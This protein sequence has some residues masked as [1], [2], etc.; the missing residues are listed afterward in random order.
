MI[1][2]LELYPKKKFKLDHSQE[3]FA[4]FVYTESF[5]PEERRPFELLRQIAEEKPF[6]FYIIQNENNSVGIMSFWNFDKFVYAE[7]FA[8]SPSTRGNGIG[9]KVLNK[10]HSDIIKPI[11]LEVE[12]PTNTIAQRRIKLYERNGFAL[13]P[14]HYIQPPYSDNMPCVEMKLMTTR[15]FGNSKEEFKIIKEIIHREVYQYI[16]P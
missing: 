7:H 6:E 10:I 11:V 15:S 9:T 2:L 1:E 8:L 4:K 16:E 12:L 13:L 3:D 5:P 14:Y